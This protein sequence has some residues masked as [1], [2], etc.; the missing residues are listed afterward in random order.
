[1]HILC[2]GTTTWY[3]RKHS[4]SCY[5]IV[6]THRDDCFLFLAVMVYHGCL[7]LAVVTISWL[8]AVRCGNDVICL[9]FVTVILSL[10]LF[11]VCYGNAIMFVSCSLWLSCHVYRFMLCVGGFSSTHHHI[12]VLEVFLYVQANH[13]VHS[14]VD[15]KCWSSTS[16]L[17]F[18]DLQAFPQLVKRRPDTIMRCVI[19]G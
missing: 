19:N 8:F 1:M 18:H 6:M 5:F 11:V 9:L 16:P 13:D 15:S 7:L 2:C 14:T 17:S 3:G 4:R 12:S 10:I